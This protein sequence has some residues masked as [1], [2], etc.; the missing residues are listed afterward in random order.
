MESLNN[1]SDV[2]NDDATRKALS[3][4]S[5][6]QLE[7]R[8][9][10]TLDDLQNA[11][12]DLATYNSQLVSLQ[13]QPERVQNAMFNASQQL[14]QIRNRL[15]GTSVGDETLRPTQQVLLQDSTGIAQRADRATAQEPR[16]QHYPA[17]YPAEAA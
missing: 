16:R 2:P 15:N 5:L 10:Q 9:T 6:R 8:V 11:Q 13:T 3:T 17:G 1:L 14:Q 4:L 7:S 12:N